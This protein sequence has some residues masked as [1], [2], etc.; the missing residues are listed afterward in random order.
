MNVLK[1]T[2]KNNA[3]LFFWFLVFGLYLVLGRVGEEA[4]NIP[5]VLAVW[6]YWT[7]GE[8]GMLVSALGATLLRALTVSLL[9]LLLSFF[10]VCISYF[11]NRISAL[12][13]ILM[14]LSLLPTVYLIFFLQQINGSLLKG[15]LVPVMVLTFSNLVLFFFYMELRKDLFEEFNKEYHILSKQLGIRSLLLSARKKVLLIVIEKFRALFIMV[16]STTVFAEHKLD[17]AGG[18]YSLLFQTAT[19]GKE[20]LDIF[21]GQ[22]V[23]ILVFILVF[24]FLYD[25]FT[26]YIKKR[27]F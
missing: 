5:I 10:A 14:G 15:A 6:D 13:T 21:Y 11:W 8:W 18:I 9:I 19:E 22:L 23:F 25:L 3:I 24:L 1:D 16:F 2:L 27:C 7:G 12:M 4:G 26:V 20:R 17:V